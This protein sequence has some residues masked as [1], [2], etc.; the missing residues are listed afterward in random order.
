[1]KPFNDISS[2]VTE[3]QNAL[4]C[5]ARIFALLEEQPE[6]RMRTARSKT[7]GARSISAM[8]ISA[9]TRAAG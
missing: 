9:T 8:S 5:A 4:A 7:C 2:V 6:S 3:M 1:M